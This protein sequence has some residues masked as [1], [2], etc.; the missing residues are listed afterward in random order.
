MGQSSH[1]GPSLLLFWPVRK[2]NSLRRE[3]GSFSTPA[4]Q[5]SSSFLAF[6]Q[7]FPVGKGHLPGSV[8]VGGGVASPPATHSSSAQITP[9]SLIYRTLLNYD[10]SPA[11]NPVIIRSNP[12]VIPIECHYPR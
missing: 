7:H 1:I 8:A 12:A 10:P 11:S 6:P 5:L 2:F 9:D 4:P 3:R